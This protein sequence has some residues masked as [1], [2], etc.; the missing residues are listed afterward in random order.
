MT[1]GC[2]GFIVVVEMEGSYKTQ[3]TTT[4]NNIHKKDFQIKIIQH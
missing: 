1:S 2:F 3:P 4:S